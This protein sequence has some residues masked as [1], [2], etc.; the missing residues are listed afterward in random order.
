MAAAKV[1]DGVTAVSAL[2]PSTLRCFFWSSTGRRRGH[3][4][5]KGAEIPRPYAQ[6]FPVNGQPPRQTQGWRSAHSWGLTRRP[7]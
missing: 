2:V 7:V 1:T 5:R 3:I 6:K 4:T